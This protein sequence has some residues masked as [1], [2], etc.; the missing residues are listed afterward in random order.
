MLLDGDFGFADNFE[1][2]HEDAACENFEA[3]HAFQCCSGIM[4]S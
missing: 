1:N 2:N 3:K 4:F